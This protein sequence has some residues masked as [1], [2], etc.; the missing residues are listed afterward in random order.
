MARDK[1]DP[2]KKYDADSSERYDA[3]GDLLI[4][5]NA[6]G[7][8]EDVMFTRNE[9]E[10]SRKRKNAPAKYEDE[11]SLCYCNYEPEFCGGFTNYTCMKH[12]EAACFH[13]TEEVLV[14]NKDEDRMET[15]HLFGCAPLTRGSGG[16]Y[17]TCKA[18]LMAHATPKSIACCY[19]GAYCNYNLTVPPYINVSPEGFIVHRKFPSRLV[20]LLIAI[21]AFVWIAIV[22]L[23]TI[24]WKHNPFVGWLKRIPLAQKL[25][26]G[27]NISTLQS[28]DKID[29]EKSPMLMDMSSGSG[30]GLASLNQRTVAQDL[31]I[32]SVIGK[33]RYGEVK[34]A[35]YKGDRFVAV[36]TFYTTEEDSWKNEKEIYQTQMLNHENILQFVAADIGS[37]DSITRMLLIT[38]FH[39]FGSLYEYLQRGETLSVSEALSLAHSAVCGL[40]HLHSALRGTGTP[41]KPA[42]AHR[43]VK[44]KN[45]IVKRE[46]VC[47]IADFGLALSEDMV[48]MRTNINIQVGT[49]RYM[50]PEVLDK[51]L[52]VKNFYHFKM[53]DIYSFSL[54]VWE[55]LRRIQE[56]SPLMRI[57][58]S[59]SGIGSS[60]SGSGSGSGV[61]S[62]YVS[63][64]ACPDNALRRNASSGVSEGCRHIDDSLSVKARPPV[65]PFEGMVDSDPSF[66]QMRRLVCV[67]KQRPLLE[68]SWM[69]DVCLHIIYVIIT[70][71]YIEEIKQ[72]E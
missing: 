42:I 68:E 1:G 63:S 6:Q 66:E 24:C 67:R 2:R 14:Y 4:P 18:H 15:A 70:F 52:N 65:Q 8:T 7:R 36:K 53:A 29:F 12:I 43:D 28:V 50:A 38:D 35:L 61:G 25:K 55:I 46:G 23:V 17:F 45:I 31:E 3:D 9:N 16:S 58:E 10:A 30:S 44:S 39:K 64:R 57:S 41:Q 11:R 5:E 60:A 54:V 69:K 51:S 34:K 40:E 13:F 22:V 48:K 19:E 21:V 33:G 47:C 72:M 20:A 27:L 49:K 62:R 37:E 26:P 71:N 56:N 32:I 59:D